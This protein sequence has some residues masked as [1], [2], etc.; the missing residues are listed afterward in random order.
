[1]ALQSF[2][3]VPVSLIHSPTAPQ[4][5]RPTDCRS[6]HRG[7]IVT[8]SSITAPLRRPR[9]QPRGKA[10]PAMKDG[11]QTFQCP[12]RPSTQITM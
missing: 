9:P 7:C 2:V 10:K 5:H 12:V 11:L 1:M 8:A 4:T 6:S 3:W